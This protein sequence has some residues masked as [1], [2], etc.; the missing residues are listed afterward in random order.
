M[1]KLSTGHESL[2]DVDPAFSKQEENFIRVVSVQRISSFELTHREFPG[3]ELG[4][5]S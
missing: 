1:N 5:I 4:R 2:Q 3:Q